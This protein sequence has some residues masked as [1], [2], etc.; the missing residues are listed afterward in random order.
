MPHGSQVEDLFQVMLRLCTIHLSLL[1]VYIWGIVRLMCLKLLDE[2]HPIIIPSDSQSFA[3]FSEE[4][5]Y[6][7]VPSSQGLRPAC[8][9]RGRLRATW[10]R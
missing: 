8:I 10:I 9:L 5:V 1:V 2:S 7:E 4:N 3:S 6:E